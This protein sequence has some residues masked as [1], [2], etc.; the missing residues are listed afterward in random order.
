[1]RTH[2]IVLFLAISAI[3]HSQ[4]EWSLDSCIRYAYEHNI[5]LQRSE[6]SIENAE[7]NRQAAVGGMLPNL[8]GQASHGY[9]WGQRID[10]FT[11]QFASQR[12]QSNSFG[13]STS[14]NLFNGFQQSLTVKQSALEIERSKWNYEKLRNDIGLNVA[15]GYLQI[16]L[17][18]E[19]W[20]IA[21][22]N[23]DRT[24]LQAERIAQLV[25]A[26]SLAQVNLDQI[27]AQL[28]SDEATE[29]SA[30]NNY[31]MAKLALM[32]FLQ[33]PATG[34]EGFEIVS[35]NVEGMEQGEIISNSQVVVE[36]ATNNFPEIKSAE[37]GLKSA[38]MGQAIARG[39]M[40]PRLSASYSY[41]S[42]YSGASKIITGSPDS[43]AYP[44]GTVFGSNFLVVSL[45]Q[46]V[47]SDDDFSVKPFNDQLRDNVNR[48][49]FFS[50]TVPIFNGFQTSSSIK[51]ANIAAL[52]AKLALDQAKQTLEQNVLRAYTDAQASLANYQAAKKSLEASQLAFDGIEQRYNRGAA[53]QVEYNDARATLDNAR[54]GLVRNKYEYVFRLKILDF[55]LGKP[56]NLK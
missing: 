51:R 27:Y 36:A 41:G 43:L 18:K 7:I 47:Y 21:K 52:D 35:P 39:G 8:N 48:S 37:V 42:G 9:N 24:A 28:A 3:G 11:N 26:G 13:L 10:P 32:Q 54:A 38:E 44:I 55:Y 22:T 53:N 19:F 1:M 31:F 33:L 29:V 15:S 56:I 50:L 45:P 5:S 23:R 49:L 34:I 16:L 17:T 12:I 4:T 20:E 30:G 14:I 25:K 6:L 40:Y 2:L 46:A